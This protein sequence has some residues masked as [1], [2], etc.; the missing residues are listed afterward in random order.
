MFIHGREGARK[1]NYRQLP[2][3]ISKYW[4]LEAVIYIQIEISLKL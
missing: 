4:H 1:K 3:K 2:G